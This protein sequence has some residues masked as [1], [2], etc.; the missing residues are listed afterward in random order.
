[1]SGWF[2]GCLAALCRLLVVGASVANESV[3]FDGYIARFNRTY[4]RGTP[5]YDRRHRI[6]QVG[7][8]SGNVYFCTR[9]CSSEHPALTSMA[10]AKL[11]SWDRTV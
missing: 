1:M 4:V 5:E 2:L 6:F 11:H 10:L 7:R 3:D 8:D 9:P